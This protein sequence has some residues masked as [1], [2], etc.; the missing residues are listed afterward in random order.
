PRGDGMKRHTMV[1]LAVLLVAGCDRGQAKHRNGDRV[2]RLPRL[3][4]VQPV[5]K[6]LGRKLEVAATVEALK[7]VDLA[8]RIAGVV[9]D[10]DDKMDIGQLVKKGQVLCRL[11]APELDA[12][13][14][15]KESLLQRAH[16]QEN[17]A[18]AAQAVAE[19]EVLETKAEAKKFDADAEYNRLRYGRVQELVR[20]RAQDVALEQEAQRQY[21]AAR[22]AVAANAARL[23][24]LQAKVEAAK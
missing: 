12:D 2:E 11:S 1:L 3:E 19:Q 15:H 17:L 24:K 9:T 4:V 7:K 8:A 16:K 6:R 13:K 23:V 21:E 10:L 5:R 20:Q 14:S 22:A 18:E